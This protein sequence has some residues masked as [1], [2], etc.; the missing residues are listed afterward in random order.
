MIR[1]EGT[2]FTLRI[3]IPLLGITKIQNFLM[4][5]D[6]TKYLIKVHWN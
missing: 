1:I 5:S 6:L 2:Y 4:I 3:V